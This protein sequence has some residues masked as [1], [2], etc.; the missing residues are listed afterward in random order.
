MTLQKYDRSSSVISVWQI[1]CSVKLSGM[2]GTVVVDKYKQYDKLIKKYLID[3]TMSFMNPRL[4]DD[5]SFHPCVRYRR[6]EVSHFIIY[7]SDLAD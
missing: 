4:L 7:L 3:L 5:V 6:W 2:P 1:E